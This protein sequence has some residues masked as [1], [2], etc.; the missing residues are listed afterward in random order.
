MVVI[1]ASILAACLNSPPF[2]LTGTVKSGFPPVAPPHF[3][4]PDHFPPNNSTS[5]SLSFGDT[6]S[7]LGSAPLMIALISILQNVAIA[8]AFGSGQS[9]DATQE[10]IALGVS[11]I[12]A[13]FFSA[14][15]TA[16]SFTRSA[17]NEASGVKSPIGGIFTG[18]LVIFALSFLTR[19]FAYIPKA[20]LA[21][22]ILCAVLP[23]IEYENILPMWRVSSKSLEPFQSKPNHF[24]VLI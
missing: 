10:M 17:V 3:T 21:A 12:C 7:A 4:L 5:P 15:P 20:S 18:L 9:I 6:W 14:L 1:V 2:A 8:K 13:S 16:G 24:V 19:W 23:M 22:V 11:H